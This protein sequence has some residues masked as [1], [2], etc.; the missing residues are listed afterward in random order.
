MK[1]NRAVG[2]AEKRR[3]WQIR[4]DEWKKSGLTQVEYCRRN[5]LRVNGLLYWKKRLLAKGCVAALVEVPTEIVSRS[6][7][8]QKSPLCLLIDGRFRVEI[9]PGFDADTLERL[10]GV[11]D[12][13]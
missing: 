10:I 4:L 5:N 6:A 7:S 11:L 2:Y 12:R 8:V 3:L 13:R 1:E 9:A